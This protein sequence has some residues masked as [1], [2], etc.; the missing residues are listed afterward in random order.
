[1]KKIIL[2]IF[3]SIF[4]VCAFAQQKVLILHASNPAWAVDLQNKL[5]N[6]AKFASV[7]L[8]NANLS[9]P[10]LSELSNYDAI[11]VSSDMPFANDLDLGN[12]L[13][14][15]IDAGGGVVNS[16]FSI[17]YNLN[18]SNFVTNNYNLIS[19]VSQTQ[20]TLLTLVKTNPT[21]PVLN[22]VNSFNGGSASYT[23]APSATVSVG[24]YVI[25][26]WNNGQ[27]LVVVNDNIGLSH[28]K[29]VDLNF[30]PMSSDARGDF[31]DAS[32]DGALL[33]ANSLL[34]VCKSLV[35]TFL[36]PGPITMC[37]LGSYYLGPSTTQGIWLS[38]DPSKATVNSNGY[39]TALSAGTTD[40]SLTTTGG[41]VTATITVYSSTDYATTSNTVSV[42]T[43]GQVSYKI[44]NSIPQPQGPTANLFMGYNGYNYSSS[45]KPTNPGFYR[46]NN[47]DLTTQT[48][49]CPYPFYIFR[50][51]TCPD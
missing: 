18:S 25:A 45:I 5:I 43:D 11:L 7:D 33:I 24:S 21:H 20:E 16:V 12:N 44:N 40:I 41:S 1:M 4:S 27:P 29:R 47:V 9:T 6:T 22:G 2:I 19:Q 13:A 42:I 30:Y 23:S 8:F 17:N 36:Y 35:P 49:G 38:S 50:C 37:E 34:Y 3:I 14:S 10:T 15:Y 26:T 28:V 31:W 46:A 51:T 48:A 39:V 32:T